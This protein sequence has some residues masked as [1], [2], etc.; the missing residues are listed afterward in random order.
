MVGRTSVYLKVYCYFCNDR[1]RIE[2]LSI[3]K[4]FG[5]KV[6]FLFSLGEGKE[7][8]VYSLAYL[9]FLNY[10]FNTLYM[11]I[12]LV[13]SSMASFCHNTSNCIRKYKSISSHLIILSLISQHLAQSLRSHRDYRPCT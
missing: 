1:S 8:H 3:H 11:L 10:P 13:I 7:S 12:S 4:E 5:F 6:L 2:I 9:L